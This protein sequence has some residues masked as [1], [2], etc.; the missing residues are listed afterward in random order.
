MPDSKPSFTE[1][2]YINQKKKILEIMNTNRPVQED[3]NDLDAS[4][5]K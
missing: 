1:N 3:H 2:I 5:D 4:D